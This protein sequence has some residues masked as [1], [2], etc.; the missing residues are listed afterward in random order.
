M[1]G[2]VIRRMVPGDIDN[3]IALESLV[4]GSHPDK[5]AYE[6]ACLCP[7]NVY[8]VAEHKGRAVAYCTIVTSYETADLCNIAVEEG[9]RRCHIAEMLLSECILC[10]AAEGV[11]RILLEA[12]ENNIPALEFYKKTG[13]KKI[14]IRK[15]Y[16]AEPREDAVVMEKDL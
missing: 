10:C 16:Y 6:K 12:R 4:F 5:D 13:F 8:M 7:G 11:E 2:I 3:V 15:G 1:G 9:Y 14:G